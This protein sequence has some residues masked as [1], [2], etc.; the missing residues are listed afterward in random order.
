MLK[1][2]EQ[3]SEKVK[4]V[5]NEKLCVEVDCLGGWTKTATYGWPKVLFPRKTA[6]DDASLTKA[7]DLF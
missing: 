3:F 7:H 4:Q 2:Y 5:G 6:I 1:Y